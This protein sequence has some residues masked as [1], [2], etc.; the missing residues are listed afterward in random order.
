MLFVGDTG[1]WSA[2]K[3]RKAIMSIGGLRK[4]YL[5]DEKATPKAVLD[6]LQKVRW[7]HF[8]CHGQLDWKKPFESSL[9]LPGGKLTLLDIARTRIP[10]AEFAFLSACHTAEQRP[11]FSLDEALHLAAAMQFCGFRSVVGTMWQL[12]DRDG[13]ILADG[14]YLHLMDDMEEG[15]VRFKRAAA[16]VREAALYLRRTQKEWSDREGEVEIRAE[17][18]VNLIHIGA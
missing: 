16:A 7:V 6:M 9:A 8:A 10:N 12:L 3:E 17:R 11:A 13:P 4:R 2:D 18:W 14:V 1:L 5:I 15:E